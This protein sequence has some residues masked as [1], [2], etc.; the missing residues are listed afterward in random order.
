MIARG[1]ESLSPGHNGPVSQI[2]LRTRLLSG[3]TG[4]RIPSG[5]PNIWGVGLVWSRLAALGAVDDGSNPSFPTIHLNTK[6]VIYYLLGTHAAKTRWLSNGETGVLI[7]TWTH[8]AKSKWLD[9]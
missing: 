8:T 5:P 4:V 9:F 2:G 7:V 6:T 3:L 1:F